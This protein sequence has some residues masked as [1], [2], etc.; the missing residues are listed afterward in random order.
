[1]K[2]NEYPLESLAFQDADYYDI[3]FWNGVG[4]ET[5]KILGS[6]IKDGIISGLQKAS[7]VVSINTTAENDNCY[8]STATL[9]YTDPTGVIG[10]GF[11]VYVLIGTSTIGG[12]AYA[13]GSV[14]YRYYNGSTFVNKVISSGAY[15]LPIVDG[16][17]NY[18]LQTNGS[19]VVSWVAMSSS[20]G[21][22]GIADSA[23][24]ITYYSDLPSA[25]TA[26]SSGTTIEVF[27]DI[28]ITSNTPL[29]LK[30]GVNINFNGHKYTLNTAGTSNAISDNNVSVNCSLMNGIINRIGGTHS[31]TDSCTLYVDNASSRITCQGMKFISSFG[32]ACVSEGIVIGGEFYGYK[33]GF[34]C[35]TGEVRG[36]TANSTNGDA[37]RASAVVLNCVGVSSGGFGINGATGAIVKNS[38]FRSSSSYGGNIQGGTYINCGFNS[39]ADF[40]AGAISST[41]YFNNCS[42]FSSASAGLYAQAAVHLHDCTGY[43]T[44]GIGLWCFNATSYLHNCVGY[45]TANNGIKAGSAVYLYNCSAYSSAAAALHTANKVYNSV[46]L[47]TWNNAGGHAVTGDTTSY[48]QIFGCTLETTH[49]SANCLHYGSA[50]NVFFGQN[51]YNGAT[52]PVNANISQ[53]QAN[54]PDAY[55]NIKIG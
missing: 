37:I 9:T 25:I 52:T 26:A 50:I 10:K 27:T 41:S 12:T 42:F 24:V 48:T 17:P 14:V 31:D 15:T 45:S 18:V 6:T 55:G 11:K 4:Y 13:A 44:A 51:I 7:L 32:N 47:S 46:A 20:S 22:C 16:A 43:S 30:D 2:I 19:G 21:V 40:G 28:I 33:N 29:N 3:D 23:G 34:Y 49:A 36:I 38:S 8:V 35:R 39:S 1:M 53:S 54:A 5:K